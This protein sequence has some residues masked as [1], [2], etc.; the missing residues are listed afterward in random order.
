MELITHAAA[1]VAGILIGFWGR[2]YLGK[3]NPAAQAA[4]DE[5]AKRVGEEARRRF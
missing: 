4:A 1:L 5:A 2:K 3:K